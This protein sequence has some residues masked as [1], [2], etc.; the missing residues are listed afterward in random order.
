MSKI[1]LV[2]PCWIGVEDGEKLPELFT[3][4]ISSQL[5]FLEMSKLLDFNGND[6]LSEE[7]IQIMGA[8]TRMLHNKEVE[9]YNI[10][11]KEQHPKIP[12]TKVRISFFVYSSLTVVSDLFTQSI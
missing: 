11:A 7:R 12:I 9:V 10:L 5:P 6:V 2:E 8:M 3:V 1:A 4:K